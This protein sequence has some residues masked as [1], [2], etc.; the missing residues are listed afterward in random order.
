MQKVP[1]TR[2][3]EGVCALARRDCGVRLVYEK[4]GA[5]WVVGIRGVSR[6]LARYA[7][8]IGTSQRPAP[9]G[10]LFGFKG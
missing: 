8:R 9:V 1:R 2:K 6:S 7:Q 4:V 10:H 5:A 3:S